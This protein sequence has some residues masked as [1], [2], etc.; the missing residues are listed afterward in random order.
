VGIWVERRLRA[1]VAPCT[2]WPS[3]AA[4]TSAPDF[5]IH[6]LRALWPSTAAVTRT[7][8]IVWSSRS[9]AITGGLQRQIDRL[10]AEADTVQLKVSVISPPD[11]SPSSRSG[12]RLSV[13]QYRTSLE[14]VASLLGRA[15]IVYCARLYK[16]L[17]RAQV[18]ALLRISEQVPVVIRCPTT[19]DARRLRRAA[20]GVA[21]SNHRGQ[22]IIAHC[23][24]LRSAERLRDLRDLGVRPIVSCNTAQ[25]RPR[26]ALAV[27]SPPAEASIFYCGRA[28]Q[29]KNL[30]SLLEAWSLIT[31]DRSLNLFGPQQLQRFAS[32]EQRVVYGG[33]YEGAPPF[34]LG[35]VVALP[36]F[37]EGHSN[38]LVEAF[39]AGAV[40]V[41]SAVP[42][43]AEH[44]ANDQGIVIG[45]PLGARS[46]ATAIVSAVTLAPEQR[47]RIGLRARTYFDR[48]FASPYSSAINVMR[49][50]L[51]A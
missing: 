26:A 51:N 38:V 12:N 15:A 11:G 21:A 30:D 5:P 19:D 24:N 46:I 2:D 25:P 50:V 27:A 35:D 7:E 14:A 39:R 28:D 18:P 37:R 45:R 22:E 43:V 42:G 3:W 10:I 4:H 33:C 40:V 49:L 8:C 17:E 48:N 47:A 41:G 29:S 16:G 31:T 44:L 32:R 20:L 9:Q 36:S 6:A 34:R 23:L 13:A 1:R